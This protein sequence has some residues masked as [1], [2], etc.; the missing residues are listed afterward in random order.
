MPLVVNLHNGGH[1]LQ[2]GLKEEALQLHDL[3]GRAPFFVT[4][5]PP[6]IMLPVNPFKGLLLN[7]V[8]YHLA[9]CHCDSVAPSQHQESISIIADDFMEPRDRFLL[10]DLLGGAWEASDSLHD[11][12]ILSQSAC[13]VIAANVYLAR[14]GDPER[15]CAEELPPH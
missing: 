1:P 5:S 9:I 10:I 7:G 15:F 2:S 11:Q 14:K 4:G 6:P 12:V 13:L 8:P 3:R